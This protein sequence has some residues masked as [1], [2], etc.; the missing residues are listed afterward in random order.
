MLDICTVCF[1]GHRRIERIAPIENA[2]ERIVSELVRSKQYVEFIVGCDGEFDELCAAV[3]RRV[4]S[5]LGYGNSELVLLLPYARSGYDGSCLS[6]D[7]IEI[8]EESAA[9]HFK[10]A[11]QIRNRC[12]CDRSDMAVCFVTRKGGAYRTLEYA[13]SIGLEITELGGE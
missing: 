6:Y 12:M 1:F 9:A 4:T 11:I 10:A 2:L 7:R 3:V 8:C 5:G 13:K